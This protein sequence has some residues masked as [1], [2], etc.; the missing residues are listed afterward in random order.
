MNAFHKFSSGTKPKPKWVVILL[1]FRSLM[2]SVWN[3]VFESSFAIAF[4]CTQS[5]S[6]LVVLYFH[7]YMQSFTYELFVPSPCNIPK[8]PTPTFLLIIYWS[9]FQASSNILILYSVLPD[10]SNIQHHVR[11][12][13][14]RPKLLSNTT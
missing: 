8:P 2:S 4:C 11:I 10:N 14:A 9:Y 13:V 6:C 7:S 1:F 3:R 12:S 5:M